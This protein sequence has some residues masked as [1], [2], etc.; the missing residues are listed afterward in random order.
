MVKTKKKFKNALTLNRN[1]NVNPDLVLSAWKESNMEL[2][3]KNYFDVIIMEK[4]PLGNPF[5]NDK[6]NNIKMW[7]SLH[8]ILKKNGKIINS[9]IFFL[10]SRRNGYLDKPKLS[11]L[12]IR[13]IKNKMKSDIKKLGFSKVS[14]KKDIRYRFITT[15]TK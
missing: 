13:E 2:I 11:T 15:I 3:P 8:K 9:S 5:Q 4:C 1:E 12:K 6:M 7:K 14:Y 10:Y